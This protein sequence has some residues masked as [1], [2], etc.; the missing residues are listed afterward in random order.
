MKLITLKNVTPD[1]VINI[2]QVRGLR[3]APGE[4][5]AVYPETVTHPAVSPYIPKKLRVLGDVEVVKKPRKD[6]NLKKVE[7]TAPVVPDSDSVDTA[8]PVEDVKTPT[9][10]E[11]VAEVTIPAETP[12]A[13]V[14]DAEA[15]LDDVPNT[16]PNASVDAPNDSTDE[17]PGN[18]RDT[19]LD[20]PGITEANVDAVLKAYTTVAELATATKNE[21]IAIG[22][23]K[24]SAKRVISWASSL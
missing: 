22:V 5:K 21:L 11:P 2:T 18:L 15:V 17:A 1:E 19:Y 20:A 12:V 3:L 7:P 6:N 13:D 8:P 24:N 4:S 23:S 10:K 9:D 14:I 16:E